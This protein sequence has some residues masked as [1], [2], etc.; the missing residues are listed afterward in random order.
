MNLFTTFKYLIQN[1][2][3]RGESTVLVFQLEEFIVLKGFINGDA[4]ITSHFH[5]LALFHQLL[6][7]FH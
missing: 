2:P 1:F 3:T 6:L 5:L 4:Y 7:F